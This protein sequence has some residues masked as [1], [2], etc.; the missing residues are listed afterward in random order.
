MSPSFF[1]IDRYMKVTTL[2]FGLN[3]LLLIACQYEM[4]KHTV[5]LP[6][7]QTTFEIRLPS[8]F[9]T[10]FQWTH[11]MDFSCG[12][13]QK[14]RF[15]HKE[16]SLIQESGIIDIVTPDSLCQITLSYPPLG[17]NE[18]IIPLD[19][20]RLDSISQV[21]TNIYREANTE[22]E[23]IEWEIQEVWEKGEQTY[24]VWGY[25]VP[26]GLFR[27]LPFEWHLEIFTYIQETPMH[28]HFYYRGDQSPISLEEV[29]KAFKSI[30]FTELHSSD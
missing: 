9:D 24:L 3:A 23:D 1:N 14:V 21:W 16:Y 28:L 5:D 18:T 4:P 2:F 13:L 27:D 22:G 26:F 20:R 29:K 25:K 15:A 10:T 8:Q 19:Q 6:D 12:D 30:S 7:L 17:C 11:Y